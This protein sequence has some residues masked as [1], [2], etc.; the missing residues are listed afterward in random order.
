MFFEG[1][2][3]QFSNRQ[4]RKLKIDGGNCPYQGRK[5]DLLKERKPLES[6]LAAKFLT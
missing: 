1:Y 5:V 4:W 6:V 3:K 2:G